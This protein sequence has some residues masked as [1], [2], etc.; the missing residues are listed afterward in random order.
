MKY[1]RFYYPQTSYHTYDDET[2]LMNERTGLRFTK[3]ADADD[4]KLKEIIQWCDDNGIWAL[5]NLVYFDN[6]E[7]EIEFFLI[8]A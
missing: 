1:S 8:W 7:Q 6:K 2:I 5:S 3:E 4:N